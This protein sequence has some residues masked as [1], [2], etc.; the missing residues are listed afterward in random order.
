[1]AKP[2]W[3]GLLD[4]GDF[5]GAR[6]AWEQKF[7]GREDSFEA[8]WDLAEVE[9]RW[10]DSRFFGGEPGAAAHYQAACTVLL[11]PGTQYSSREENDRRMAAHHRVTNKLYAMD[12]YG[13]PRPGHDGRPHPNSYRTKPRA[14]PE[15]QP[16]RPS[17]SERRAAT[18]KSRQTLALHQTE[19]ATLF[20]TGDHSLYRDLGDKWR[21]AGEVLAES[22]PEAARRAYAWS[23]Y[24]FERYYK[25]W[26]AHLPASR[27]DSDGGQ[28]IAEIQNLTN[29][30]AASPSETPL[31]AW[32]ESLLAGDWQ[33]ARSAMGYHP[34]A[35]EFGLLAG[36][37][38]EACRAAGR[39]GV[40]STARP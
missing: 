10:G 37:L 7:A 22:H 32:V 39:E 1:M 36:L 18:V 23:V 12:N 34:P 38:A 28:D 17:V 20:E 2:D 21:N 16:A 3:A 35:P 14:K 29:S 8:S 19:L 33:S 27:W 24:Y 26:T 4:E 6:A 11:P 31:P 13:K 25:A 9:E 30:L 15:P 40:D 5:P